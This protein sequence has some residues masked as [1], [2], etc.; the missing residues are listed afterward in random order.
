M[1][2]VFPGSASS[3][4]SPPAESSVKLPPAVKVIPLLIA[5]YLTA[6]GLAYVVTMLSR[7]DRPSWRESYEYFILAW[8]FEA[9]E[10]PGFI[11]LVSL[12]GFAAMAGISIPLYL[13][14]RRRQ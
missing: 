2:R 6:W 5:G 11:W 3:Q 12:L 14:F 4:C 8:T 7:G 10:V 1:G 9:G 13:K